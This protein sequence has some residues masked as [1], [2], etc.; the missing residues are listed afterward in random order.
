MKI[1]TPAKITPSLFT[2]D[3]AEECFSEERPAPP[4]KEVN[5]TVAH[6]HHRKKEPKNKPQKSFIS[7]SDEE[8]DPNLSQSQSTP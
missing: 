8:N 5:N 7:K 4:F 6:R 2:H 3:E 1:N